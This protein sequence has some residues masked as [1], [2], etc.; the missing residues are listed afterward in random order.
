[1]PGGFGITQPKRRSSKTRSQPVQQLDP[2]VQTPAQESQPDVVMQAEVE[3]FFAQYQQEHLEDV[4]LAWSA[5]VYNPLA[6]VDL[7][8][9]GARFLEPEE[10]DWLAIARMVE[11]LDVEDEMDAIY[12]TAPPP[13]FA[14]E[15]AD[16]YVRPDLTS[17]FEEPMLLREVIQRHPIPLKKIQGAIAQR[18]LQL[19]WTSQQQ[20]QFLLELFDKPQTELTEDDWE[21]LLFE[22]ESQLQDS[23]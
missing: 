13:N 23:D 16:W 11:W 21:F 8:A 1:M 3:L 5:G 19:G 17:F 12:F 20:T 10:E 7:L 15:L 22:L 2:V 9:V 6:D 14:L 18:F 4:A